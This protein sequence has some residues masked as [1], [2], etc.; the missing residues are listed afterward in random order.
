MDKVKIIGTGS[1]LPSKVVTNANFVDEFGN[2]TKPEALKKLLGT[3]EHRVAAGDE[4]VSDL[5]IKA[6]KNV[7]ADAGV[8]ADNL[9]RIIIS[10]TP[11]DCVEPATACAVQYG[12]N[13]HCPAYDVRKS[14][15]GFLQALEIATMYIMQDP[16]EKVLVLAGALMHRTIPASIVQHRAIFGDGAAGFL[17]AA[18]SRNDSSGFY[19]F[20]FEDLGQHHDVIRW[21][22]AWSPDSPNIPDDFKKVFYM[23]EHYG[24]EELFL[25]KLAPQ[26][27]PPFIK[28]L[29]DKTG[30]NLGSVQWA[31]IHYPTKPLYE[32]SIK[33][34]GLSG[35]NGRLIDTY[36]KYANTV[37][38]ELPINFD[39]AVRDGRIKKGN[40]IL[41]VSFGAGIVMGGCVLQY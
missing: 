15:V 35:L 22:E 16:L 39:E 13:A 29:W 31:I 2:N 7:L 18:T 4:S 6:G 24:G 37:S 1:Y 3:S 9:T 23:A 14:C 17:L 30:V 26:V 10:A 20:H 28:R 40:T 27:L 38:A 11:G 36:P 41:L 19:G 8:S 33:L 21:P 32:A 5:L 25:L 12:L 34:M